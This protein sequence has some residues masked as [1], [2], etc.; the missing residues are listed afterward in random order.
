MMCALRFQGANPRTSFPPTEII[1]GYLSSILRIAWLI[2][3]LQFLAALLYQVLSF[4][5]AIL[6]QELLL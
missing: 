4:Q 2:C 3:E 5:N 6:E 1:L